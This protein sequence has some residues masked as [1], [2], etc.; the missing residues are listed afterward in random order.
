MDDA[1]SFRVNCSS[2]FLASVMQA[3]E[4]DLTVAQDHM[5]VTTVDTLDSM[6]ATVDKDFLYD[7]FV[8]VPDA[9]LEDVRFSQADVLR[10]NLVSSLS[11]SFSAASSRGLRDRIGFG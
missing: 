9:D 7:G 4:D 11:N 2:R 6:I 1:S 3:S 8:F 5:S 10:E